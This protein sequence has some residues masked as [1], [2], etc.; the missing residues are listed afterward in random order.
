MM[1][2]ILLLITGLCLLNTPFYA[3]TSAD[4]LSI[5][6]TQ[7]ETTIASDGIVHNGR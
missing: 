7:W 3:Q 5:V 1:K 4:S 2:K 6:S